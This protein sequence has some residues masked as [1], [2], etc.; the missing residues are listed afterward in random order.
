M[1]EGHPG[2]ENHARAVTPTG[3]RFVEKRSSHRRRP[4]SRKPRIRQLKA[5]LDA[6]LRRHDDIVM[7]PVVINKLLEEL[8]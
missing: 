8:A 5:L 2:S 4:V 7:S 3:E 6:G 1:V